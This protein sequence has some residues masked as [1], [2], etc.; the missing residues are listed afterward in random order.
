MP[1][2]AYDIFNLRA[3]HGKCNSTF[4]RI[5]VHLTKRAK[6]MKMA[7]RSKDKKVMSQLA[8]LQATLDRYE[9]YKDVIA[10]WNSNVL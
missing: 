8:C 7:H 10:L 2:F 6:F 3:M 5:M 9:R 1:Q 4:D